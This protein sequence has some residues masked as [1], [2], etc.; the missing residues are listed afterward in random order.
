MS[1]ATC[2]GSCSMRTRWMP[3]R[4]GCAS[5][6]SGGSARARGIFVA[7]MVAFNNNSPMAGSWFKSTALCPSTSSNRME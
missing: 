4:G 5:G 3:A 7:A 1:Q 6:S 2:L